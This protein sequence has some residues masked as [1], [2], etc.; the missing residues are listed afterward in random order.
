[1]AKKSAVRIF[2]ADSTSKLEDAIE[3]FL[4]HTEGFYVQSVSISYVEGRFYAAVVF[5]T[6]QSKNNN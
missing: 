4:N 5:N 3:F 2:N 6:D 1:M